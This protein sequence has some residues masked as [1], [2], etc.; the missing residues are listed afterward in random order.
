LF[1]FLKISTEQVTTGFLSFCA[2]SHELCKKIVVLF[3]LFI[4]FI[5]AFF[6]ETGS[7]LQK[8]SEQKMGL[9][10]IQNHSTCF[11]KVMENFIPATFAFRKK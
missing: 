10:K 6:S 2:F 8:K 1:K 7:T 9:G 4:S 3:L 11:S 5:L